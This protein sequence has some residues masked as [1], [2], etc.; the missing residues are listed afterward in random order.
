MT[1]SYE[2]ELKRQALTTKNVQHKN[3]LHEIY[4]KK[5][6]PRKGRLQICVVLFSNNYN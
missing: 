3:K 2:K 5:S 1:Q 4:H 6:R